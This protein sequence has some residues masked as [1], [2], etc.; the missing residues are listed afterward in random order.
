MPNNVETTPTTEGLEVDTNAVQDV[1]VATEKV[2]DPVVDPIVEVDAAVETIVDTE[3]TQ[4]IAAVAV[5]TNIVTTATEPATDVAADTAVA[6]TETI[7]ET[8]V[9]TDLVAADVVAAEVEST[10]VEGAATATAEEAVET[11]VEEE[12]VSSVQKISNTIKAMVGAVAA[13]V[14]LDSSADNES[15]AEAN[16]DAD[17]TTEIDES[18]SPEATVSAVTVSEPTVADVEVADVEVAEVEVAEATAA[19]PATV[20]IPDSKPKL[21]LA[22][23]ADE[24]TPEAVAELVG[25]Y[26]GKLIMVVFWSTAS[27]ADAPSFD[28]LNEMHQRYVTQGLQVIAVNQDSTARTGEAYAVKQGAKFEVTHD[29]S[30]ALRK[31]L[32]VGKLPATYLLNDAG[33][34]LGSHAGFNDEIR[35][36]YEDEI[37]RLLKT[38]P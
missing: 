27:E 19:I 31:A 13:A 14:T 16:L 28:W 35:G 32:W 11:V 18:A 22:P 33:E 23:A 7:A 34:L 4:D 5:D 6:A 20:Q 15:D 1:A 36:S 10:V 8:S 29:R 12:D 38:L 30:G 24:V 21:G 37:R 17:S 2:I 26:P 25:N 9:A 3:A